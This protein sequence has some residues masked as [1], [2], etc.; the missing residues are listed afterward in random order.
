MT[1]SDS[2]LSNAG[3]LFFAALTAI[4]AALSIVA[5]GRDLL[6]RKAEVDSPLKSQR[7]DHVPPTQS[8]A[9]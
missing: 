1:L 6:P 3:W 2:F 5:F 9:R 8:S 7:G 4:I